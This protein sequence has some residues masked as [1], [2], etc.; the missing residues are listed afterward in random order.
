MALDDIDALPDNPSAGQS[1]H[2]TAH[3][4]IHAGLK[5]VKAEL[6]GRLSEEELNDT[7]VMPATLVRPST[8]A[9]IG[10]SISTRGIPALNGTG[11]Y[12]EYRST[13]QG[14]ANLNLG[15]RLGTPTIFAVS[16]KQAFEVLSE[17]LPQVLAM[18]PKPAWCHVLV[19][20]NDLNNGRTDVQIIADLTAIYTGL[21]SAGIRP[22]AGTILPRTGLTGTKI[23]YHHKVN[24][25][26]RRYCPT[27]GIVLID[28]FTPLTNVD[29]TP[30]T[31]VHVDGLHPTVYGAGL[32]G[33]AF[34]K[35]MSPLLP[36]LDR[37]PASNAESPKACLVSN[38][39]M[40]GTAGVKYDAGGTGTMAD[41]WT[42]RSGDGGAYTAVASKVAR[43]DGIPGEWQQIAVSAGQA[44]VYQAVTDTS[45]WI[46]GD[47]VFGLIEFEADANISTATSFN[48]TVIQLPSGP[49]SSVF[50]ASFPADNYAGGWAIPTKGIIRTPPV[51]IAGTTT[52][53]R[54][55]FKIGGG[56][57]TIRLGRCAIIRT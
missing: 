19:G 9:C 25:W 15:Q 10:D 40:A 2:R 55:V 32:M 43:T 44:Q 35:S 6:N 56:T 39:L 24:A 3:Q 23:D 41:S 34:A 37:L 45:R 22:I 29:G 7:Y 51:T 12:D 49:N 26:L 52:D 18:N 28:Y 17:Q 53:L 20:T 27:K 16:G 31:G 4:K 46:T 21:I 42:L 33:T 38:P 36:V 14:W 1:G 57:P 5:S 47:I 8:W 30:K 13:W 50:N 48:A 11:G 54:L